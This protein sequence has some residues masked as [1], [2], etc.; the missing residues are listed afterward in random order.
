MHLYIMTRGIKD[1]VDRFINDLLAVY[2][3]FKHKKDEPP[4]RL[5]LAMRPIQL[6][7]VVYPEEHHDAVLGLLMPHYGRPRDRPFIAMLRKMMGLK[8]TKDQKDIIPHPA[9][10]RDFVDVVAIGT[11]EDLKDKDGIELL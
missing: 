8:K 9:F 1:R 3:P 7:E 6:W 2:L 11:K 5:Q 4:G 10:N